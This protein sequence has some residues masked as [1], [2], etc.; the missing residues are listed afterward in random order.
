MSRIRLPSKPPVE[1]ARFADHNAEQRELWRAFRAGKPYR[2]P[3][4][5]TSNPRI[6]LLDDALNPWQVSFREYT[7][8]PDVMLRIEVAH[9]LFV[10]HNIWADHEMGLP[11]E[12]WWIWVDFQNF[13]EAAWLG[14]PVAFPPDNCP[15]AEPWLG[16]ENKN[17]IF[18]RGIPDP[19]ADGGW[20]QRNWEYYE[21]FCEIRDRG[22]E[23]VGRPI[24]HVLPAGMSTDGP[25]TL[26]V[27]LRG[28]AI[29]IDLLEDPDY[30]HRLMTL[31][32]DAI[33][34]R[35][36]AYRAKMGRPEKE[37]DFSYAD[38]SISL[39]SAE[40]FREHVLDYHRRIVETFWDGT[41]RLSIHLCGDVQRHLPILREQLGVTGLDSGW[42]IDL[43]RA[44]DELG[45]EAL[46][47]GGPPVQLLQAGPV[48]QIERLCRDLLTGPAARG[49]LFVLR[50]ANNLPPKTPTA[51]IDAMYRA[52]KRWGRY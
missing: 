17:E 12:G 50:E 48:E 46:L 3:M 2:V 42:P 45:A 29:C 47:Q 33:I 30:F 43:H 23:F 40:Q 20:M 25:F 32:T 5:I 10:Q 27:E 16:D 52:C 22:E 39:L 38:D 21:Y 44:R 26:A 34:T 35:M 8:D 41:G 31:I 24:G 36:R 13:Y 28:P 14:S 51:H 7:F 1:P 49:G 18:D 15:Y 9:R 6:I 37:P 11:S 4:M 19:F